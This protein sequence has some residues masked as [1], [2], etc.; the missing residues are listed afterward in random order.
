MTLFV[1]IDQTPAGSIS[2]KQNIEASAN[3]SPALMLVASL[4]DG[5]AKIERPGMP[6]LR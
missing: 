4:A 1:S 6:A 5:G 2:R 3:Y